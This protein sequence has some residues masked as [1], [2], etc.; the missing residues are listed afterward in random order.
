MLQNAAGGAVQFREVLGARGRF[1]ASHELRNLVGDAG[2]QAIAHLLQK[3]ADDLLLVRLLLGQGLVILALIFQ[4]G[5]F[6][7]QNLALLTQRLQI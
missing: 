1:L 7:A 4:L 5:N 2:L 3:V 6:F